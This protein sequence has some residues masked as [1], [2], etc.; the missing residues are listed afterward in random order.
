MRC[1]YW[2]LKDVGYKCEPHVCHEC[3][4]VQVN[5]YESKI[6]AILTTKGTD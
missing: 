4:D 2:Y 5:A 6:F 1:H 3:H